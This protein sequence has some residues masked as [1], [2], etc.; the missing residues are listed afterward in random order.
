M[1]TCN[2]EGCSDHAVAAIVGEDGYATA[3]RCRD[4]LVLDL[5]LGGGH[6]D[7]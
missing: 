1:A 7:E 3:Y 2:V 5:D 6:T 4:C